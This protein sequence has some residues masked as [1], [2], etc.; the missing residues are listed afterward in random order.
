MGVLGLIGAAIVALPVTLIGLAAAAA[1]LVVGLYDADDA[2]PFLARQASAALGREVRFDG[3]IRVGWSDP[4]RLRLEGLSVANPEWA[5]EPAMLKLA[6]LEAEL[7]LWP[8]LRGDLEFPVVRLIRPELDLEREGLAREGAKRNTWTFSPG[9]PGRQATTDAAPDDRTEVP[10]VR[11]LAIEDGHIRY[12][13]PAA[14][15]DVTSAIST[16]TGDNREDRVHLEAQGSFAGKSF[17]ARAE[18]GSLEYLRDDPKPYPLRLEAA[19]GETRATVEGRIAEPVRLEGVDLAVDLSGP[20]LAE[21]FPILGIPVPKTRPYSLTGH[22]SRSAGV[23]RMEGLHGRVGES[24]LSGTVAMET[25]G[26]RPRITGDLTSTR[27]A[28]LDLAGFVG[29]SPRGRGDYETKGRDRVIPATKVDLERLRFADMDVRFRGER[30][31]AP[32]APLADLEVRFL[33]DNGHLRL[34]PLRLGMAG[35]RIAGTADVDGSG[36]VAALRADLRLQA[37]K[38]SEFFRETRFAREMGGSVSGQLALAGRGETVADI[39]AGADG[40]IG[41]AVNGGRMTSLAEAGLKTNLLETLGIVVAGDEPVRFNCLVIDLKVK[42]GVAHADP[43]VLD[44][45][46][47]VVVG[48]GAID[49]RRETLDLT[50]TGDSKSPQILAT[51]VPVHVRGRFLEPSIG[52]DATESAA[53][54]AAAVAL[55][56]LLTPLAGILATADPGGG[57]SA[58]CAALVR[59]ARTPDRARS[60]SR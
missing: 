1:A 42:D 8:L 20:D 4:L 30:V 14:S 27:L 19:V 35:G 39:L 48:R 36:D 18:G 43:L 40:E 31:E 2:R 33:L 51:H 24:D 22:L 59:D 28:A 12:R 45:A 56:V 29:A 60:G 50:V 52:V 17:T 57:E 55:G 3:P 58:D 41:V 49:L 47:T 10:L 25:G 16:A 38:L 32:F 11:R 53:R 9:G 6:A 15:V 26:E 23:W 5:A 54:G 46:E 44:T 21:V 34:D 7:S 37:L 13:D